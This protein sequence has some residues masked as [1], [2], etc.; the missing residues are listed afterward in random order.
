M[1]TSKLIGLNKRET[2]LFYYDIVRWFVAPSGISLIMIPGFQDIE[3][4]GE[5]RT[6]IKFIVEPR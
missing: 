6:A 3:I 4:D 5:E 1:I 2:D